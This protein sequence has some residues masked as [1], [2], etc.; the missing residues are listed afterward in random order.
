M[1]GTQGSPQLV[2]PM[3]CLIAGSPPLSWASFAPAVKRF[4]RKY[5]L[6]PYGKGQGLE[7]SRSWLRGSQ[8]G[9]RRCRLVLSS[10]ICSRNSQGGANLLHV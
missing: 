9:S 8:A 1:T 5:I 6:S 7:G 3:L 2:E 4:K 10:L